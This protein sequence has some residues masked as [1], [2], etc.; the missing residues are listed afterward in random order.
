MNL[1]SFTG[2]DTG[3]RRGEK[4][5]MVPVQMELGGKDA[6]LVFPTPTLDAAAKAIVKGGVLVRG[7]EVHGVKLVLAFEEIADELV[8]LVRRHRGVA[9]GPA[10][11]DADITAV[12]SE[13]SADFIEGLVQDAVAKGAR[14]RQPWRREDN[15]VWPVLVDRGGR[16]TCG[17]RGRSR[18]DRSCPWCGSRAK[19]RRCG[20]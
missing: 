1:V 13:K 15:L 20:S 11:D 9:R 8:E 7:T 16:A 12:V 2:G 4:A 17:W 10:E 18:S 6:C 19:R 5:A 14:C 3:A